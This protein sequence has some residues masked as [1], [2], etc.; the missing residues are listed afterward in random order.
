MLQQLILSLFS[1]RG[2]QEL[3]QL[4]LFLLFG[5]GRL[6]GSGARVRRLVAVGGSLIARLSQLEEDAI[7]AHDAGDAGIVLLP[8]RAAVTT[9]HQALLSTPVLTDGPSSRYP[10]RRV[11]RE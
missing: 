8:G 9:R 2:R 6:G 3:Q 1:Q 4:V 5:C 10:Q 11:K 7:T